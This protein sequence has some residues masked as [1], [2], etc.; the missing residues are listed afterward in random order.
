MGRYNI[1][2]RNLGSNTFFKP[3]DAEDRIKIVMAA[4]VKNPI[5]HVEKNPCTSVDL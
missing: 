3:K 4:T 2:C 5:R 1:N